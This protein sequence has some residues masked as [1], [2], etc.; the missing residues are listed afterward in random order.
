MPTP[1]TPT[2]SILAYWDS[3]NGE[4]Q[5][6]SWWEEITKIEG[7][8]RTM[9]EDQY[10]GTIQEFLNEFNIDFDVRKMETSV[11]PGT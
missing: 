4:I 8:R 11:D 3:E 7:I 2:I 6:A 5:I 10:S 1:E 9:L